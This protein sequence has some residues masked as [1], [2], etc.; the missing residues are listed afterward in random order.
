MA[1]GLSTR[2]F[3]PLATPTSDGAKDTLAMSLS[4][5]HM[6]LHITKAAVTID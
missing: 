5:Y 6:D 2:I 1:A 3:T 4:N